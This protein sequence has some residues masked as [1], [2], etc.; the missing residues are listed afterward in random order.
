MTRGTVGA[1]ERSLERGLESECVGDPGTGWKCGLRAQPAA[2]T[3][4]CPAEANVRWALGVAPCPRSQPGT[5]KANCPEQVTGTLLCP[6]RGSR[7]ASA[8]VC[9]AVGV[10]GQH[11]SFTPKWSDLGHS[12]HAAIDTPCMQRVVRT[13]PSACRRSSALAAVSL[14]LAHM[15]PCPTLSSSSKFSRKVRFVDSLGNL[16]QQIPLQH[17]HIPECIRQ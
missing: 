16:A 6:S 8:D 2:P 9:V 13:Q 15:P 4:L 14:G 3:Q 17:A 5:R 7:G 11:R 1:G 12:P 10:L